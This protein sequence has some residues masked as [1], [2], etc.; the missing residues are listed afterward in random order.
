ME[1]RVVISVSEAR[2][3]F[4]ELVDRASR[5]QAVGITRFGKLVA[6][7]VPP[8]QSLEEIFRDVDRIREHA[9]LPKGVTVKDLIEEGRV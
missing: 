4:S 6:K 3:R 5:G 7:I 8:K 1:G 9:K 2:G